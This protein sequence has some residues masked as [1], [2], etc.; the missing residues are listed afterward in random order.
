[1]V[2]M[3]IYVVVN[4]FLTWILYV[5]CD[6][7]RASFNEREHFIVYGYCLNAFVALIRFFIH[8]PLIQL[9]FI[10]LIS[11]STFILKGEVVK[12]AFR[13]I[14]LIEYICGRAWCFATNA[15]IIEKKQQRTDNIESEAKWNGHKT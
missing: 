6:H 2:E 9:L 5:F 15:K 12:S 1:M 7:Y 13:K 4:R 14:C 10:T 8:L 11:P 3:G